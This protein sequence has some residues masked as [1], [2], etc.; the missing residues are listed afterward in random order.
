MIIDMQVR[1]LTLELIG[2]DGLTVLSS[3]NIENIPGEVRRA[4]RRV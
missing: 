3:I 2:P 1:E 4:G